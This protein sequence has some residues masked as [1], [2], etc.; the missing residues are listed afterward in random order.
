MLPPV[1]NTL[2]LLKLL[3]STKFETKLVNP[4]IAPPV[5]KILP[6]LKLAACVVVKY[7]VLPLIGVF[8]IDAPVIVPLNAPATADKLPMV[9]L[10]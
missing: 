3:A 8:K 5:T 2:G 10:A 7:P 4:V 6:E 9:T 1:T